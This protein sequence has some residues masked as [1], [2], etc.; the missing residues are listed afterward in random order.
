[1]KT[2]AASFKHAW[3][4]SLIALALIPISLSSAQT[5][6]A[7]NAT[8]V[9]TPSSTAALPKPVQL[10]STFDVPL[11]EIMA[12]EIV[13]NQR[14][15]GMAMTIVQNGVVLSERGYGI[16][17][18]NNAEPVDNHTVFRLASLSKAFAGTVS[19]M[20][21]NE[22]RMRWDTH[23]TDYMPSLQL[24]SPGA[25]Q[26]LTVAQVLSH[27]VGLG[28]NT[29]DRDLEQNVDYNTLVQR[30]SYA[31]MQC[32]PGQCYGYQNVAFSLIG[33]VVFGVTGEFYGE[34]VSK[35]IFKPLGMNDASY[36][37]EGI[38][39]SSRWAKP[40]VRAGGGW[41]SITPKPTYY[42]VAPAAGVNASIS[43]MSQWL[44]A[45]T[46][47]R[48]DVLSAPLL[49]TLH[50]PIISTPTEMRGGGGSWRRQRLYDAGYGIGWRVYNYAG[51]NVVFHAGLVQ[52]YRGMMAIVPEKNLGIAILWN[53]ES[54]LPVGM[55]PT[56]LDR[57]FGL[58]GQQWLDVD[59][60]SNP[61][62]VQQRGYHP[63]SE[64]DEENVG[65]S[66]SSRA[67]AK[68]N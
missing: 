60:F 42:R 9:K 67:N 62:Y 2:K 17:D 64:A 15:P 28:K 34:T 29:Y 20:L 55:L 35:K 45:H 18:V 16:T 36:G 13:A 68:P 33:D 48:P 32:Q 11:F 38:S 26:Q 46:G 53:G 41:R 51:H 6:S 39:A 21:V 14:V 24:S 23:I 22:G 30:L 65:G 8:Q 57:A 31:P 59:P 40:H 63:G 50:A 7:W 4:A 37:L 52:G 19:G 66:E 1:M 43:D 44:L 25:A 27:Q 54:S 10:A 47:Y 5:P 61:L 3:K 58:S 12:Q 56:I 49:A